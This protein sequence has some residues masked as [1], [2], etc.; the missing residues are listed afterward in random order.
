MKGFFDDIKSVFFPAPRVVAMR[1]VARQEAWGFSFR[2][3]LDQTAEIV[4]HFSLLKGKRDKRLLGVIRPSST[5][6]KGRFRM[7][8]YVYFGDYGK[9]TT[10]VLE[11]QNTELDLP[12]FS[13]RPKGLLH[14]FKE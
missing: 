11:F 14:T 10:T 13:I 5:L 1:D 3:R 6:V 12:A 2:Q 4:Q 8:D 9:K 7:Y